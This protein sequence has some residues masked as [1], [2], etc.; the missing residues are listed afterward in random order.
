MRYYRFCT[1]APDGS[2]DTACEM[3]AQSDD[4][5]RQI[6]QDLVKQGEFPNIEVWRDDTKICFILK[7]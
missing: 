6:A 1:K 2:I 7:E 4:E 5:A 3:G